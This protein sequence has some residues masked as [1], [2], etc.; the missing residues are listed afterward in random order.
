[1]FSS[2]AFH[3]QYQCAQY[4]HHRFTRTHVHTHA[5]PLIEIFYVRTR[6]PEIFA[7]SQSKRTTYYLS[8]SS[9]K[10]IRQQWARGRRSQSDVEQVLGGGVKALKGLLK[11]H[12]CVCA[13]VGL[14]VC[15]CVQRQS[16]CRRALFGHNG[17]PFPCPTQPN[18]GPEVGGRTRY[19]ES[20][21]R[22]P[23]THLYGLTN[24]RVYNVYLCTHVIHKN[25]IRA[26]QRVSRG[27]D[28]RI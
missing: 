12:V 20:L 24:G 26:T 27:L 5:Y 28:K 7:Q 25:R 2:F 16:R 3:R 11:A 13:R 4:T 23:Y 6:A 8:M 21:S 9:L 1:M 15:V 22:I 19:D 10:A 17:Y 14:R 18:L